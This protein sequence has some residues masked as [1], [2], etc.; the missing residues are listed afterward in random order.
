M[1]TTEMAARLWQDYLRHYKW[2]LVAAFV[3]MIGL[4]V[5]NVAF[6]EVIR[7]IFA[8]LGASPETEEQTRGYSPT[9]EQVMIFGPLMLVGI[10]FGLAAFRYLYSITTQ[11]TAVNVLRD[12]QR[13]MFDQYLHYDFAQTF[14]NG[15]GQLVSRFTNDTTILRESLIRGPNAVK[16]IMMLVGLV[17]YLLFLDWMLFLVVILIYP[18]VGLPITSLGRYLR[19]SAQKMQSQ[20]GDM[21]NQLTESLRGA[22]LVKTYNLEEYEKARANESFELRRGLLLKVAFTKAANDPLVTGVGA[23]AIALVVGIAAYR[24]STGEL[25]TESLISFIVTMTLLSQ[26]ARSIGT[27]NAVLQEG[28][29]ALQR[30]FGVMNRRATIIEKEDAQELSLSP[31]DATISF[32]NVSFA[33]GR[34][35]KALSGFS[36]EVPAGKTV[37]L[38]G[39]SG[40]GKTTVINLLPRLYDVT[41]GSIRIN[42]KDIRDLTLKSLRENIAL[43][44]QDALLFDDTVE[45][46]IR[47]GKDTATDTEIIDAAKAAAADGFID[48]LP[49]TYQTRVGDSGNE[50]SGGQRQRVA[51]ARAFLK[52]A[53]I[54]LLDEATSALDAESEKKVQQALENLSKDRTTIV[55]AHRLSTVRDADIIGVVDNGRIVE[56]GQHKELLAQNGIYA[57]LCALQFTDAD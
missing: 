12:L 20:I 16:D 1:T 34:G 4:T 14:E 7:W 19:R 40:A 50:L 35:D 24:I 45:Q 33:Y 31:Q 21:T 37:A 46:N 15:T 52:D 43:V 57:R 32:E 48:R 54:L 51:L 56:L 2:R 28:F 26:P 18:T 23:I 11:G 42:G 6:P 36:L 17:G 29:A 10:G 53:P 25:Q 8:G 9:V 22:R 27:L 30:V 47:F 3:L 44:S 41:E 55:I 39:E 13:D 5:V 49:H 38:V